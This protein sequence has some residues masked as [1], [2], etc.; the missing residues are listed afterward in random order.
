MMS[1]G[2][3]Q[4]NAQSVHDAGRTKRSKILSLGFRV[5]TPGESVS[6][7][8]SNASS[9]TT[10]TFPGNNGALPVGGVNGPTETKNTHSSKNE[11]RGVEFDCLASTILT[12][13]CGGAVCWRD[14][15]R[16]RGSLLAGND[17]LACISTTSGELLMYTMAGRRK[18]APVILPTPLAFLECVS[19]NDAQHGNH[20][21]NALG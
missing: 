17:N 15:I 9:S 4:T 7:A 20:G 21:G 5:V 12:L 1:N 18:C 8:T 3:K 11:D 6:I 19:S 14:Q 2:H 16:G 10:T 13:S